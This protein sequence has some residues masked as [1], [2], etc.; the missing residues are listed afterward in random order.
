MML[1]NEKRPVEMIATDAN[2]L[3]RRVHLKW[4]NSPPRVVL[5][6]N[7]SLPFGPEIALI[8]Y[9]GTEMAAQIKADLLHEIPPD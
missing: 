1:S 3:P 4:G 9:P 7:P 6:L 2:G 8:Y 5:L